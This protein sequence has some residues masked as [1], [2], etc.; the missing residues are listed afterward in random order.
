MR[1]A[2]APRNISA[3]SHRLNDYVYDNFG[4]LSPIMMGKNRAESGNK[5]EFCPL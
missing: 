4:G 5:R 1:Q 3:M 2:A